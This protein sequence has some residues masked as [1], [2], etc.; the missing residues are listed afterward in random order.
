MSTGFSGDVSETVLRLIDTGKI[1]W[2]KSVSDRNKLITE[3]FG[4]VWDALLNININANVG[5][6]SNLD[7]ID[8]LTKIGYVSYDEDNSTI[9]WDAMGEV[10]VLILVLEDALSIDITPSSKYDV[11]NEPTDI[12]NYKAKIRSRLLA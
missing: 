5:V 9:A 8:K 3:S 10:L 7:N 1:S 6:F 11:P 4:K 12:S 2:P